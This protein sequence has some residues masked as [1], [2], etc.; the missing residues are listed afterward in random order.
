MVRYL[1]KMIYAPLQSHSPE[2]DTQGNRG[3][4]S[5]IAIGMSELRFARLLAK[6]AHSGFAMPRMWQPDPFAQGR[7]MGM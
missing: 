2:N 6:P 3:L 5:K 7:N 1:S 4:D